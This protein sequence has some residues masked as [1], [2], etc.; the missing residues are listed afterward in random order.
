MKKLGLII[1][2]FAMLA[3][4]CCPTKHLPQNNDN[5]SG[6]SMKILFDKDFTYYQFDSLCVADTL[7]VNLNKWKANPAVDYETGKKIDQYFYIK[8]L[9][10][11]ESFYRLIKRNEEIYNVFKRVVYG[12]KED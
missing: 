10:R 11:N 5:L 2:I 6:Y 3:V 4:A 1:F 9:G 8:R 7:P 12:K